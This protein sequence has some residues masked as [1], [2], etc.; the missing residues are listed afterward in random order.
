MKTLKYVNADKSLNVEVRTDII[1]SNEEC[2]EMSFTQWVNGVQ[3]IGLNGD[4]VAAGFNNIPLPTTLTALKAFAT[5]NNYT[6]YIIDPNAASFPAATNTLTA[7]NVTTASLDAGVCGVKQLEVVTFPATA[8]ATQGD[9]IV[10]E[11]A[12]TG[13]TAAIWLDI[14]ADGTAPTGAKYLAADYQIEVDIATGDTAAQ[15]A[16]KAI[17]AIEASAWENEISLTDNTDGSVDFQQDYSGVTTEAD[18]ENADGSGAGSI[19]SSTSAT[20]TNGTAYE[21]E[22]EAEGG[23]TPY[24]WTTESTLPEGIE[25]TP[26]GLLVGTPRETGTFGIEL[27]ATDIWGIEDTGDSVDL[28]ITES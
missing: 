26:E 15:V 7:L 1:G 27:K 18:P 12:L 13:E 24:V 3:Q 28:V 6:L 17:T 20:G 23:N 2:T 22:V 9:Y 10:M 8:D 16:A 4:A 25:L 19:T 14:D 5:D 21:V 11:N